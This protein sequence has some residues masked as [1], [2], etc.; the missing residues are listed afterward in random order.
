MSSVNNLIVRAEKV[1]RY[2]ADLA[3]ELRM[4][5]AVSPGSNAHHP[6]DDTGRL[7]LDAYRTHGAEEM[8]SV[9]KAYQAGYNA[10]AQEL[11]NVHVRWVQLKNGIGWDCPGPPR[12]ST[13][14]Y[15]PPCR[16]WSPGC[17]RGCGGLLLRRETHCHD[18]LTQRPASGPA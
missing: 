5:V 6:R 9:I 18:R 12:Q 8:K 4:G 10:R 2:A 3:H 16:T 15:P 1:G 14:H 17:Q 13:R 7:A 11:G